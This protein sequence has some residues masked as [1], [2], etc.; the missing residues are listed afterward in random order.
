MPTH[1]R[2]DWRRVLQAARPHPH[3][4]ACCGPRHLAAGRRHRRHAGI[5]RSARAPAAARARPTHRRAWPRQG[6]GRR[7]GRRSDAR[8]HPAPAPRVRTASAAAH[9]AAAAA[10]AH[11]ADHDERI[12]RVCACPVVGGGGG[13]ASAD[14]PCA[15]APIAPRRATTAGHPAAAAD[16]RCR[17]QGA[18]VGPQRDMLMA[19][20]AGLCRRAGRPHAGS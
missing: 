12:T 5:M 10:A 16:R 11:T 3:P 20:A 19:I 9:A 18:R 14:R 7:G 13:G 15:V 8:S 6:P 2:R 17:C 4:R 1:P